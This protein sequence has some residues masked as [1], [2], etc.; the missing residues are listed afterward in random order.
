MKLHGCAQKP[1]AEGN[2]MLPNWDVMFIVKKIKGNNKKA[3]KQGKLD[4][5]CLKSCTEL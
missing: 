4:F 1:R 3:T 5:I 2:D